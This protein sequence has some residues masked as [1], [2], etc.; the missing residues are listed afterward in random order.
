[1]RFHV[2]LQSYQLDEPFAAQLTLVRFLTGMD[3][4]VMLEGFRL[5]KGP[6]AVGA[7]EVFDALVDK[8]HVATFVS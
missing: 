4:H 1:M 7:L 8:P 5:A 6:V 3:H 2:R